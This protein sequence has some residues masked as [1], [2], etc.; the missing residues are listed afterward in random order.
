MEMPQSAQVL[1]VLKKRSV[2]F[3]A[4]LHG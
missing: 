1:E 2:G 4:F 3:A